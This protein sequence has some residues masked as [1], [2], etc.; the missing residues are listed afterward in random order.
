MCDPVSGA[1]LFTQGMGVLQSASSARTAAASQK[2]QLETQAEIDDINAGLSE[3]QA[4]QTLLAGQREVQKSQLNT[5]RVK[6]AQRA[7]LAA[8]GIDLGVGTAL[9][10]Q[11]D[12]DIFGEIEANTIE[13]NAVSA[14]WGYRTQASN[15][16]VQAASSR[17]AAGAVNPDMAYTSSL[18]GGAGQVAGS[19][20]SMRKS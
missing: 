2:L 19:W 20:Y 6:G 13:S 8:N 4:Q 7:A 9:N 14:A 11:N 18:I 5:A 1:I 15:Q 16:K 12:T 3:T 17:G 10:L